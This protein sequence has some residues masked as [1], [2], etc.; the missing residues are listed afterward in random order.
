MLEPDESSPKLSPVAK[1]TKSPPAAQHKKRSSNNASRERNA[2]LFGEV[3]TEQEGR[4]AKDTD[5][6]FGLEPLGKT[7]SPS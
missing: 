7:K 5:E 2:F 1:T 3:A 4:I 6:I